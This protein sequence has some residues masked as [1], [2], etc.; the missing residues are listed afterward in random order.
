MHLTDVNTFLPLPLSRACDCR[1]YDV[2]PHH[3]LGA[4][5][6]FQI[7]WLVCGSSR[8]I[9][10]A[11][12]KANT[13]YIGFDVRS[14]IVV[15][16]WS[17]V[18]EFT[19]DERR[20]LLQFVTGASL[21]FLYDL[22]SRRLQLA[23]PLLYTRLLARTRTH[24]QRTT[25]NAQRT[26]PQLFGAGSAYVP[27]GGFAKLVGRDGKSLPF[28]LALKLGRVPQAV[29]LS[30]HGCSQHPSLPPSLSHTLL[31]LSLSHSPIRALLRLLPP[32]RNIAAHVL[33]HARFA[34]VPW[35][36]R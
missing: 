2:I 29:S 11:D 7:E 18:E 36:A 5:D 16:F 19:E 9:D 25:H 24:A 26:L 23:L 6:A 10:V 22:T 12:W 31:C 14:Q 33:Q 32:P 4:F 30:F 3:M 28:T 35:T 13:R 8:R 20:K 15:V 34:R 1:R 27:A 17:V 21:P